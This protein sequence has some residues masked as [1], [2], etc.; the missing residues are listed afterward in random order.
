MNPASKRVAI[1]MLLLAVGGGSYWLGIRQGA[2]E[3]HAPGGVTLPPGATGAVKDTTQS[4]RKVLYWHDPMVPGQKFDK[5]G[6]SPFMD[7]QLVP[8]YADEAAGGGV[9]VSPAM[10]SSLGNPHGPRPQDRHGRAHR[11]GGHRGRK[12]AGQRGGPGTHRRLHREAVCARQLRSRRGRCADGADLLAGM[13]GRAGRVPRLAT[14]ACGRPARRRCPPTIAPLV[15]SRQRGRE[16]RA[17]RHPGG[18]LHVD[19]ATLGRRD[20]S[21]GARRCHGDARHDADAHR[22]PQ[23]CLGLRG[24]SGG[25]GDGRGDR[26]ERRDSMCRPIRS[27]CCAGACRRCCRRSMPR[28]ARCVRAIELAES[29]RTT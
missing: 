18:S 28:A 16:R 5:P 2:R 15:D 13:G 24:N 12:R 22:E 7:M 27:R 20:R 19:R 14:F 21:R 26:R 23:R 25:G 10:T 6:K 17:Q 1:V 3:D 11:R 9:A 29:R 8:V 4:E